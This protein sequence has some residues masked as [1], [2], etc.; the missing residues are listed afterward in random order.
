MIHTAITH[1]HI[2]CRYSALTASLILARL[3]TYGIVAHIKG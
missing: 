1:N 2:L 3:Q